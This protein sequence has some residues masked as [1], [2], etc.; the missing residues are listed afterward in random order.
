MMMANNDVAAQEKTKLLATRPQ[1]AAAYSGMEGV[2]LN[3]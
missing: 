1:S 2:E 3:H